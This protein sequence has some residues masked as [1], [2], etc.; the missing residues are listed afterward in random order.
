MEEVGFL[1][2]PRKDITRLVYSLPQLCNKLALPLFCFGDGAGT[3]ACPALGHDTMNGPHT[4]WALGKESLASMS[5]RL[6]PRMHV[7]DHN[8]NAENIFL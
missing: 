7:D 6:N 1:C 5:S 4:P 8:I 3:M 2:E